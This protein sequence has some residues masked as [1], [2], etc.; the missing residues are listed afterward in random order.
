MSKINTILKLNSDVCDRMLDSTVE[1][2]PGCQE[3]LEKYKETLD[4]LKE[5]NL[6]KIANEID[7]AVVYREATI[8]QAI[9]LK[10]FQDGMRFILNS[11]A[12]N[13]VIEI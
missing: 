10:A 4:M 7:A 1:A 12:G 5:K 9:Y 6:V 2:N 8:Q 3:A 13:E 11:L